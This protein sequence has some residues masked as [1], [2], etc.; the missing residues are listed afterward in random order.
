[1][2]RSSPSSVRLGLQTITWGGGQLEY[3]PHVFDVAAR[4]GYTGVEIG[5]RRIRSTPPDDLQ[6]LLDA[7]DLSFVATHAGG[8]LEDPRQ[9][10]EERRLIDD[11]LAYV[12]AMGSDLLMFSGLRYESDAQIAADIAQ[13]NRMADLCARHGVRLLYHNHNWEFADGGKAIQA[14]LDQSDEAVGFCPDIG[15]LHKAR[16]EIVPF[17]ESIRPRIG[18]IHFKDFASLGPGVDTVVLGEG[19]VPLEQVAAWINQAGF[20]DL[21]V[22]AEQDNAV[23]GVDEDVLGN[24]AFLRKVFAG[25]VAGGAG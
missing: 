4:G 22:I 15:W 25:H 24:G 21:W 17:L 3:F 11:L 19:V 9:A 1:M 14:I 23:G 6:R 13:L 5:Y 7:Q 8:N 2:S 16:V 10:G 18:A 20:E 12:E